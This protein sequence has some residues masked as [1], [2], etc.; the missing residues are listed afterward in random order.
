MAEQTLSY[1]HYLSRLPAERREEI[2][3]V[4]QVMRENVPAGYTEQISEK[5]LT[6]MAGDEWYL[7]LANQKNYISLYL[8]SIYVFPELKDKLDNS[9]KKLKCGKGCVNFK[10]AEELPLDTLGEIVR[11]Y[12]PEA[13]QEHMR[14]IRERSRA[15]RKAAQGKSKS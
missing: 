3:R 1:E 9:G 12:K 10:R 5:Y 13:Y 11:A 14:E 15:E 2:A 6:F 4:W 7:A 8:C